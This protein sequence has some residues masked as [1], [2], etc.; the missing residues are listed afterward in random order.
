MTDILETL[1]R[2]PQYSIKRHEK[3]ALLLQELATLHDRHR[4]ACEAYR[5]MSDALPETKPSALSDLPFF[6]VRL[7]KELD[8]RSVSDDLVT[9]ILTSSGTTSQQVAR[10]A[11]D[12]ETS[13]LQTK[14]LAAIV[15]SFIGPKRLPMIIV[16]CQATIQKRSELSA[17]GA[18][19][20]GLS[21]FGR[22]HF[23]ALDDEMRLDLSGLQ[24]FC[25]CHGDGPVLIFG[26]TFMIWQYLI[27]ALADQG[28]SIAL[29]RAILIHGGGWK[30]LQEQSVGNDVFKQA[31]RERCGIRRVHNFYGMV[32]QVGSVYMECEHGFFHAPNFAD[33]LMR[34]P[35]DWRPLPPGHRGVIETV[36]VLPRSYPGQVLLTEDVGTVHGVDDCPCGRFGTR[37]SV[38]G[39]LPKVELRGCSD[40]HAYDAV[41]GASSGGGTELFPTLHECSAADLLRDD[42][43]F[44][45]PM[46]PAFSAEAVA[47]LDSLSRTIFSLRQED[48]PPHFAALAFWLRRSNISRHVEQFCQTVGA[49]EIAVPRGTAFHVAPSNVETIFLYSWALSLLAGNR[50][51]V[52]IPQEVSPRMFTLLQA[53]RDLA[54]DARWSG[55]AETNRFLSYPRDDSCNRYFSERADLR[56]IWG[57]DATALHFRALP[58][59][60]AVKDVVFCD[61]VSFCVVQAERYLRLS[62]EEVNEAARLFHND[63]YQFDQKACSSP[64]IV[65]FAG[66]REAC[67]DASSRFWRALR[68]KAPPGGTG[69]D[70]SAMDKLVFGYQTAVRARGAH[71]PRGIPDAGPVVMRVEKGA[72]SDLPATCGGGFFFECFVTDLEELASLVQRNAQTLTYLGLTTEEIRAVGSVLCATGI[73]RVVPV[74]KALDF[75]PVWDGYVLFSELTKR[76]SIT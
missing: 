74:G 11:V 70:T 44:T 60:A 3:D 27:G 26:F 58:G 33:V 43:F 55:I 17:R 22:N 35:V 48:D 1:F 64:Q 14:A 63:A 2:K 68:E 61:K 39:R 6:P 65:Y 76:V 40:T 49:C 50:N 13:M 67:H 10:I 7:F 36:S 45:G 30:K 72:I 15:T 18:G 41:S 56:I 31:V 8:L 21:N 57:G 37:F 42:A 23:Y 52:R 34:D 12:R 20:V 47:F 62:D 5:A 25:R 29:E 66:N 4:G 46:R 16:D 73:E 69:N 51:V 38:E 54:Q 59:K 19:L 53:M 75:A 71:W 9:K 24:G 28:A 32:E